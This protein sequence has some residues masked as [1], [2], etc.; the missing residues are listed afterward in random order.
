MLIYD[1][2]SQFFFKVQFIDLYLYVVGSP[3]TVN[4]QG[5]TKGPENNILEGRNLT[6]V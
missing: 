2:W 6:T 3:P 5:R 1:A 4:T